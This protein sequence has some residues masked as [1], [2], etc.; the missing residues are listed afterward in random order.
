MRPSIKALLALN[1]SLAATAGACDD[2]LAA[3][4]GGGWADAPV[5][6]RECLPPEC[7]T[8]SPYVGNYPFSNIRTRRN[9]SSNTP[10]AGVSTYSRWSSGMF[11]RANN[12]WMSFDFL[13]PTAEGRLYAYDSATNTLEAIDQGQQVFF[14]LTI[15]DYSVDPVTVQTIPMWIKGVTKSSPTSTFDAWKYTIATKAIPPTASFPSEGSPA[16]VPPTT[17]ANP[18]SGTYYSICPVSDEESGEAL[19][20]QYAELVFDDEA[21]WLEDG[22]GLGPFHVEI[23]STSVIACQG[24]AFSKPQEFLAVTPN[25]YVDANAPGERS[26][27][28]DNY[29]ALANAYRA[30]YDGESRT[31][32]GT[33]V[34]F[35]DFR[36]DPPWFDQTTSAYLPPPPILGS[37]QFVLESVYKDVDSLGN[38][39]G[40]NCYYTNANFPSGVHRLYDPPGGNANLP[41][42]SSMPS[43]GATQS[44]WDDFGPVGAFVLKHVLPSSPGGGSS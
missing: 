25:S 7:T 33:P 17:G 43:C 40:A 24:Q 32:L 18:W 35:K 39:R 34:Y 4:D 9:H 21:A 14:A 23:P 16:S 3:D 27:G 8:N 31:E 44:N 36:H 22:F 42:W 10:F 20:L 12:T 38:P 30:F 37:W 2:D 13:V 1:I 28:L 41:G 11:Q 19:I 26:Y 15:T 5:S 6:F 29:T